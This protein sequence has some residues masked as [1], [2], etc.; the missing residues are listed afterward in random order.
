MRIFAALFF[1]VYAFSTAAQ[2]VHV[3]HKISF[4][5]MKL[6]I[7]DDARRL[8]QKDVDALTQS[9]KH[10]N[11]KADR[12]KTYFPIIEK[13][14]AEEGVPDD[15]KYLV[16][17]ESALIADAVS[18][19]NAVGYWQFKDF[20]AMEMGLRVDH[21]IDERKNI[22]SATRAAAKYIKKNNSMFDNWLYALQ[23]YQMGAGGVM[24]QEKETRSGEKHAEITSETYWYVRKFLAYKIAFESSVSGRGQVELLAFQPGGKQNLSALSKQ[25]SIDEEELKSYNKW[26]T[27]GDIP[28]DRPYTILIPNKTGLLLP[29]SP[30]VKTETR[31]NTDNPKVQLKSVA[32]RASVATKVNGIR[33]IQAL[34]GETPVKLAER[35]QVDLASFLKWN[36]IKYTSSLKAGDYYLLGKKRG[37]AEQDL[38]TVAAGES[39]WSV[40]QKYGVQM[41]RLRKFNRLRTDEVTAGTILWLSAM[42]PKSEMGKVVTTVAE[43]E[44]SETFNWTAPQ[45]QIPTDT[46]K[47]EVDNF[48][49]TSASIDTVQTSTQT[50]PATEPAAVDTN[51][52]MIETVN[53]NRGK[54]T[55]VV[56]PK[57]TLYAIAHM[58]NVGVMDL[59]KWNGL[60]LQQGLKI[61]QILRVSP[62]EPL[63]QAVSLQPELVHEVQSSDTLYS[64]ARKYGVTIKDIMEWN[65]KKDFSLSVGEKLKV[66]AR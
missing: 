52:A 25:F 40:S 60:D 26:T 34:A 14:F 50:L 3:P 59:V 58:Y 38:H 23:A 49:V 27:S 47:I 65:E 20:T 51:S 61:G 17:Q 10:F 31:I 9:P 45:Q 29:V 8:I 32:A 64:I 11:I 37:R 2:T 15:F 66:K 24:R 5:D 18:S 55:H 13:I 16:L 54:E 1:A 12:A 62:Q 56:Q 43:V 63:A 33:A 28:D 36:D 39:L 44:E 46:L 48:Q 7:R 42:K 57:E 6:V 35:A 30:I 53:V 21:D 41:K 19:S 4:A 22:A